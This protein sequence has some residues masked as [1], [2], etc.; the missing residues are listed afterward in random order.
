M[1]LA[2]KTL[3]TLRF[4]EDKILEIFVKTIV[5]YS[6]VLAILGAFWF[7]WRNL[8]VSRNRHTQ[9]RDV[10]DIPLSG[11]DPYVQHMPR[12]WGYRR[13]FIGLIVKLG[14][15]GFWLQS[16]L[17]IILLLA[18]EY[19]DMDLTLRPHFSWIYLVSAG[20]LLVK[21]S[22]PDQR[23]WFLV[24]CSLEE[25]TAVC[26]QEDM[27]DQN[28]RHQRSVFGMCM[29][30][31]WRKAFATS[32]SFSLEPVKEER[33]FSGRRYFEHHCI[34]YIW[35]PEERAFS[36]S[37]SA[38]TL[39]LTGLTTETAKQV[40]EECPNIVGGQVSSVASVVRHE[41]FTPLGVYQVYCFYQTAMQFRIVLAITV[42]LACVGNGIWRALRVVRKQQQDLKELAHVDEP[43]MVKRDGMWSLIGSAGLVPQDVIRLPQGVVPCDCVIVQGTAVVDESMLTG[44]PIP[45][46]KVAVR[47]LGV[48]YD[49]LKH[50]GHLLF[51]GSTLLEVS[52]TTCVVTA[53]GASTWK[54]KHVSMML[55]PTAAQISSRFHEDMLRV[56]AAVGVYSV[57]L[58]VATF[59]FATTPFSWTRSFSVATSNFVYL[60][61]PLLPL[62]FSAGHHC[63]AHSLKEEEGIRCLTPAM[64]ASAG[65][66]H[67]AIFDKTGTLTETGMRMTFVRPMHVDKSAGEAVFASMVW[68]DT[69]PRGAQDALPKRSSQPLW[70]VGM[71]TCHTIDWIDDD[72]EESRSRDLARTNSR[73]LKPFTGGAGAKQVPV[74]PPLELS[75]FAAS[76]WTPMGRVLPVVPCSPGMDAGNMSF[77][78]HNAEAEV[79]RKL[80]LD[81]QT[82]TSGAIVRVKGQDFKGW[83]TFVFIKGDPERLGKNCKA[84]RDYAQMV[85]KAQVEG[86]YVLAMACKAVPREH[87]DSLQQMP[88]TM[89]EADLELTA[90]LLFTNELRPESAP[91]LEELRRGRI[92]PVMCTGDSVLAGVAVAKGC[93]LIPEDSRCFVASD[94]Y[95]DGEVRWCDEE[96][97]EVHSSDPRLL[98]AELAVTGAAFNALRR[99]GQLGELLMHIRVFAHMTP[100]QKVE[101]VKAFQ[102]RELVVSMCGDGAN[103]TGALR[104]AQVGVALTTTPSASI[105][106]PFS[107]CADRSIFAV[108]KIARAGRACLATNLACYKI[109]VIGGLHVSLDTCLQDVFTRAW[110]STAQQLFLQ[111]IF[112][113]AA[114][115]A[116]S[117]SAEAVP[118][119]RPAHIKSSLYAPRHVLSVLVPYVLSLF[120]HVAM[121]LV[122][123][124]QPWYIVPSGNYVALCLSKWRK[125]PLI[126][127]LADQY[128]PATAFILSASTLLT[129]TLAYSSS[130]GTR[131]FRLAL[132]RSPSMVG[133]AVVT[134]IALVLLINTS[135]IFTCTFNVNC[136]NGMP[137]LLRKGKCFYGPQLDMWL[138]PQQYAEWFPE[139]RH[140]N[141]TYEMSPDSDP[142][143]KPPPDAG[144][145]DWIVPGNKFPLSWKIVMNVTCLTLNGMIL[146]FLLRVMDPLCDAILDRAGEE[147]VKALKRRETVDL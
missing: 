17:L 132:H 38:R 121:W 6:L 77:C 111:C 29:P 95:D 37:G 52:R 129:A 118:T 125:D 39:S 9:W 81:R 65:K 18:K 109:F 140:V 25:A 141:H 119:L 138:V 66:I 98:R 28:P 11:G 91:A 71:A 7:V 86:A 16:Q 69:G 126:H 82:R 42:G 23:F 113:I 41:L 87:M 110:S 14:E 105:V 114:C 84:P 21:F 134:A 102:S 136:E 100:D 63:L 24:P 47:E 104:A 50:K 4:V 20:L 75:M 147:R 26:V 107:A 12:L 3:K 145:P 128:E 59:Y 68:V 85:R 31:R 90:L 45:V 89:L 43:V 139:L 10:M 15:A 49:P 127:P 80:E 27:G 101:V 56:A 142:P 2:L 70:V 74:G 30:Q 79:L 135:S 88:R 108:V 67:I 146:H 103:D 116:L 124:L 22:L 93:A 55:F 51:A 78:A 35:R 92:R 123:P 106:A 72:G 94:V 76:G 36:P 133:L 32:F 1:K 130:A 96:G 99:D 117:W 5:I 97:G 44:E 46:Q 144:F 8:H 60:L 62:A 40:Q 120:F 61:H 131:N 53:V 83:Q 19:L 34:M 137:K 54:G 112:P 73:G 58:G 115:L 143:C 33:G 122:M 57:V 13:S 64:L 48:Y